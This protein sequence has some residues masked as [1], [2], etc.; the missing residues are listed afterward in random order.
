LHGLDCVA[1]L[2]P[3]PSTAYLELELV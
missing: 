1:W 3:E 2:V